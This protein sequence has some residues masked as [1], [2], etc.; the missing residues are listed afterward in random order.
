M[1]T[2]MLVDGN[3]LLVRAVHAAQSARL[4]SD[5]VNTGPLMIFINSLAKHIRIERPSS[6]LVAWDHPGGE[7]WRKLIY[8]EY[9]A[10]RKIGA[11]DSTRELRE[12]NFA[13][14]KEFLAA[15]GV[16]QVSHLGFEADDLIG[17]A[18]HDIMPA[19]ADRIMI[20]SSD[21]DFMQLIGDNPFGVP[22]EQVRLSSG[23]GASRAE[24]DRW[25]ATR[26]C[27][28]LKEG[29]VPHPGV[30]T[31][32]KALQGDVS[33]NVAGL[34]GIGPKRA[35][36]LMADHDWKVENV[37]AARPEDE[38]AIRLN[39]RLVDLRLPRLPVRVPRWDPTGP[40]S[41]AFPALMEF[42]QRYQMRVLL[43]QLMRGSLWADVV[44][45][46]SDRVGFTFVPGQ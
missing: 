41:L 37:I 22:T 6:L 31:A 14:A 16:A 27:T 45:D 38:E 42:L 29:P 9:K 8:P 33:D 24:T 26:V 17:S 2:A 11:S 5:G 23:S 12:T 44:D 15:A 1:S 39:L 13:L 21:S 28:G 25:D 35:H 40:T 32:L 34:K 10:Q 20:L 46:E 36:K 19:Q 43:G 7:N 3:N 30:L 18:W 4:S